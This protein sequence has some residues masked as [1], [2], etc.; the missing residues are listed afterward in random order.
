MFVQVDQDRH[1]SIRILDPLA[2]RSNC[3]EREALF[4][5]VRELLVTGR[6]WRN[7]FGNQEEMESR[8]PDITQWVPCA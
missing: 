6:W 4:Q 5:R 2:W 8:L 7:S 1:I 3:T